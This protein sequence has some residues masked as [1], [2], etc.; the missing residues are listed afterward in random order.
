MSTHSNAQEWRETTKN[1]INFQRIAFVQ[2]FWKA[3]MSFFPS[4]HRF[5][6]NER[7]KKMENA[8][9]REKK[10]RKTKKTEWMCFTM[11]VG[12]LFV[13]FDL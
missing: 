6:H 9:K 1:W 10:G 2:E 5:L 4:L 8:F 3:F 12:N 7:Q 11:G 13:C